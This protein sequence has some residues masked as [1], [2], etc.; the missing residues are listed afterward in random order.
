M[1]VSRE[2]K[3]S[4]KLQSGLQAVGLYPG[5]ARIREVNFSAQV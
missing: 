2:G 3:G 4:T 5:N 1:D